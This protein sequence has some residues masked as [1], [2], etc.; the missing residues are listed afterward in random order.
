MSK[1]QFYGGI[2]LQSIQDTLL[3]SKREER[4]RL[5]EQEAVESQRPQQEQSPAAGR[6]EE[7]GLQAEAEIRYQ[8][9]FM[10][11]LTHE[12][13][14]PLAGI[15]GNTAICSS[16][17]QTLNKLIQQWSSQPQTSPE[18]WVGRLHLLRDE[19]SRAAGSIQSIQECAEQQ[20]TTINDT[21][22]ASKLGAGMFKLN[23]APCDPKEAIKSV[24]RM[25]Q[26]AATLKGIELKASLPERDTKV[27]GDLEWL[28]H[29]LIN[30]V[31]NAIK[32]TDKGSVTIGFT[33]E[34]LQDN[35]DITELQFSVRDTGIGLTL[36]E[37]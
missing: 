37:R 16:S 10:E 9:E 35:A 31:N 27:L 2:V 29:I 21:L 32:F 22:V 12:L 26:G 25:L 1:M 33:A 30:L 14:T 18:A 3:P 11:T 36:K 20:L 7:Q 34:P 5:R 19:L 4:L 6:E 8:Q 13:R 23:L 15:L 28:K 17:L 24:I